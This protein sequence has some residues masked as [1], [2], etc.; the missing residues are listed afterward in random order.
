M[1]YF[2]MK[3]KQGSDYEVSFTA[4]DPDTNVPID[5]RT[6]FQVVGLVKKKFYDASSSLYGWNNL[7]GN[8]VLLNGSLIIK[9]PGADSVLWGFRRVWYD[10]RVRNT[11]SNKLTDISYGPLTV[12]P[13]IL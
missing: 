6:D 4:N 11:S 10:I 7:A 2:Y 13:T 8:V 12:I 1:S 5:L 3:I 9:V